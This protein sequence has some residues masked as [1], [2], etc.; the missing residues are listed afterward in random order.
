M[1]EKDLD[2]VTDILQRAMDVVRAELG[3]G[4][5]DRITV[6]ALV[7]RIGALDQPVRQHWR[8]VVPQ[9]PPAEI[10]AAKRAALAEVRRTGQVEAAA[11]RY[12]IHRATLYRALK[13]RNSQTP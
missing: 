4:G 7:T 5:L 10:A 11:T 13:T 6:D 1:T 2:I 9:R 8:G 12:G 3:P